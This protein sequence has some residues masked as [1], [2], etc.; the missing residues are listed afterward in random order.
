MSNEYSDSNES[1]PCCHPPPA[2]PAEPTLAVA[3]P[4]SPPSPNRTLDAATSLISLSSTIPI[5]SI[6]AMNTFVHII[7][8]ANGIQHFCKCDPHVHLWNDDLNELALV[9]QSPPFS[10]TASL[11]SWH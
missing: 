10:A 9:A 8:S 7:Q 5:P 2:S 4:A 1:K 3:T 11:H 6:P